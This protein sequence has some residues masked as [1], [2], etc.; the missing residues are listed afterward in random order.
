ME[1]MASE[2]RIVFFLF[3]A[4]WGIGAFFIAGG[5]IAGDRFT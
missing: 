2:E 3:Q 5:D 1:G 4:A